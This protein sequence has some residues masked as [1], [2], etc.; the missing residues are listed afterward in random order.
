MSILEDVGYM[1]RA[2]F[3]MDKL[4]RKFGPFGK[5]FIPLMMDLAALFLEFMSARTLESEK[6]R[7]ITA[8]TYYLYVL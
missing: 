5:A 6:D 8:L 1:S 4:M 3:I 2:A 7:K